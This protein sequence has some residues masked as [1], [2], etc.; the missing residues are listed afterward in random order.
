VGTASLALNFYE[1]N[2]PILKKLA[3]VLTIHQLV[4]WADDILGQSIAI[5][6]ARDGKPQMVL[7]L[8]LQGI[9]MPGAYSFINGANKKRFVANYKAQKFHLESHGYI[10]RQLLE[11]MATSV[12]QHE[13]LLDAVRPV[14][15]D[16]T[17]LLQALRILADSEPEAA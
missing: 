3:R 15:D 7:P 8:S 16:D 10:L 2:Q 5:E 12:E 13:K 17:T 6:A 9:V 1:K 14:M 4:K 11:G